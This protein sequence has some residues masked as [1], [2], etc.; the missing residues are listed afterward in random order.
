M[1]DEMAGSAVDGDGNN[2]P[3]TV[4]DTLYSE[5]STIGRMVGAIGAD[6]VD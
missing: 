3:T 2:I 1:Y 6:K 4:T 5:F